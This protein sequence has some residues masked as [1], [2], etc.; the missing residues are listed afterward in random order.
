LLFSLIQI[1]TQFIQQSHHC[2]EHVD[3]RGVGGGGDEGVGGDDEVHFQ[4][5]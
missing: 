5:E 4:A 2:E 1:Q 3:V